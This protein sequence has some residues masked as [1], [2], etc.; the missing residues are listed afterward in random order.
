M[1]QKR[2]K[3]CDKRGRAWSDMVTQGHKSRFGDSHQ[4]IKEQNIFSPRVSRES[5][6][7]IDTLILDFWPPDCERINFCFIKP[8]VYSHLLQHPQ[9]ANTVGDPI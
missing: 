2:R 8:P 4:K 1:R 9:E 6:A 7:P 5:A 3:Q